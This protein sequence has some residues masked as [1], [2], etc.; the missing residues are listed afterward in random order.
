M[1][2][3]LYIDCERS[4]LTLFDFGQAELFYIVIIIIIIYTFYFLFYFIIISFFFT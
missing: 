4:M 3:R 1:V 2:T